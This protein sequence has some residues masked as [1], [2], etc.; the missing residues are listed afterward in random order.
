MIAARK[1]VL[2]NREAEISSAD[3]WNA[4]SIPKLWLYN[5]HYFDD[6]VA[7]NAAS[8][9]EWHADLIAQW[10]A[11][12]PRGHGTGWEP[13]PT[14]LR[15]VNWV[16]SAMADRP[17]D[18]DALASL[19]A[20]ARWLKTRIEWHLM[21]NHLIANAKA[22]VFSG[23]FFSG[24]EAR[25]WLEA[26]MRLL[27]RELAEQ[28]MIDGGHFER[29][30]MYHALILEDVLDLLNLSVARD[31]PLMA[32]VSSKW[33]AIAGRML[34]WLEA[35][36]HPDGE[37]S[38][39]ND[40][41]FGIAPQFAEL[42]DYAHRLGVTSSKVG[43]R[44]KVLGET[45]YIRVEQ[46]PAVALLDVGPVGPD[47]QPGHAH[48][49]TLSFELS[50][51]GSRVLVNSGTSLYEVGGERS[52]Q[53]GTAAHNTVVVDDQDSS[54]VWSAFRVGRR[55]KPFDLSVREMDG[56]VEVACAHDGYRRLRGDVVHRRQWQ[57]SDSGL[58]I[59]DTLTGRYRKAQAIFLLH[60]SVRVLNCEADMAHL[61]VNGRTITMI[62]EGG[63]LHAVP[64]T[65][66]PEFGCSL[67]TTRLEIEFERSQLRTSFGYGQV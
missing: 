12:N 38:F 11:D 43:V 52:R 6:L 18:P 36:T 65:W 28:I 44:T 2:L 26:G 62:T 54:E 32:E 47:Y 51:F 22:L 46:G 66:H 25:T 35:V 37:I 7:V 24:P 42:A 8:R 59:G 13:Y 14:S 15:I 31:D 33:R 55:A 34:G 20:Q 63:T 16:K 17:L 1:F 19:A 45:G 9:S 5:L 39:F 10:I 49:D 29:S 60:P 23:L 67:P 40:A 21:G 3:D 41:A 4:P 27:R 50:L 30:P 57:L 53:R 61:A 58:E 48:A 64:S 56:T